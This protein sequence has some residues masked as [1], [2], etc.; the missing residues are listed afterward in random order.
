MKNYVLGFAFSEDRQRVVLICKNGA[1]V[2]E[3]KGK[4][5]GVGGKI[6]PHETTYE[7]MRRE[8]LEETGVDLPDFLWTYR[9]VFSGEGWSVKVF[10]FVGDEVLA[11]RTVTD[12]D[13]VPC[14]IYRDCPEHVFYDLC[15]HVPLLV[16]LCLNERV[17]K[18]SFEEAA[19][20]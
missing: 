10:S 9:G 13:V 12:E 19:G 11:A 15:P 16:G 18:F 7:A 5:N 6:E 17:G 3:H 20:T 4:L 14:R 2:P 8:F 1:S